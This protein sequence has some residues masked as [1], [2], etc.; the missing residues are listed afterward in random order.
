[1]LPFLNRHTRGLVELQR[2]TGCRPGE[3]CMIRRADIDTA[4][5][6]WLYKPT[7]HKTAHRGKA[8]T[9]AIGPK[10]QALL[11]EFFTPDL[12]DFLFSPMRAVEEQNA[13]RSADRKTPRYPSHMKRNAAK[14][15]AKPK[16]P[17]AE[18]YTTASYSRAV[19]RG[20]ILVNRAR[21]KEAA[22]LGTKPVVVP[23]FHP[24]QIR[25]SYA[26]KV[27][28]QFGLE[29]AQVLLGH[30]QADVTQV[31]AERDETLAVNVAAKIG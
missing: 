4:G 17:P 2:L 24:N 3:A 14:R 10:A 21:A 8:R 6:V 15:V 20:V 29:A 30:S 1:V 22:K 16:R 26:T 25:H 27:R 12:D 9:I 19:A 13:A 5:S 31:Y 11:R 7:R 28:R 18:R 23:H